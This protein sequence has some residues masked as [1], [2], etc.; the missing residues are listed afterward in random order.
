MWHLLVMAAIAP[1]HGLCVGASVPHASYRVAHDDGLTLV[2]DKDPGLLT[3]PGIGVNK[4]D[5]LLARLQA[6]GYEKVHHAPHRL[7]RDTSGL[8]V[9]GQTK[10]AHKKLCVQVSAPMPAA[11]T[12]ALSHMPSC[13]DVVL[14]VSG[15]ALHETLRGP[16]LGVAAGGLGRHQCSHWE[17]APAGRGAC[18]HADRGGRTRLSDQVASRDARHQR[19]RGA[20]G[21]RRP[22]TVDWARP[23]AATTYGPHWPSLAWRPAAWHRG[24]RLRRSAP[25]LACSRAR[26]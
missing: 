6:D 13:D 26:V 19:A 4:Q 9:F 21:T 15:A 12:P 10:R 1:A 11:A 23:S 14:A 25:V 3:V 5:C 16:G 2:V 24:G 20:F 18:A 8:L 17:G 22:R 7:D